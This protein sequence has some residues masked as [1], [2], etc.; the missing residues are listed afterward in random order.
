MQERYRLTIDG[1][2]DKA[3]TKEYTKEEYEAME[4][5]DQT[6]IYMLY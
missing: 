3:F 6:K 2:T 5:I 4:D 1:G